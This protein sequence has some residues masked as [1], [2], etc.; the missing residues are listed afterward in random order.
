MATAADNR[1]AMPMHVQLNEPAH[2]PGLVDSLLQGRCVAHPITSDSCLV[3]HVQASDAEEAWCE[4]SFFVRAWELAHP[5][6][7]AV[8]SR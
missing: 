8:I 3:V 1:S 4:L 7:A 6:V 5:G 2:L